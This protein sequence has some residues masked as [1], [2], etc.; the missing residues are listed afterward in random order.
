MA[1]TLGI[2]KTVIIS[3]LTIYLVRDETDQVK[4]IIDCAVADARAGGVGAV[5]GGR[6]E[7]AGTG[8]V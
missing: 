5:G 7:V 8:D 6:R 4:T 2:Q 1:E 3:I